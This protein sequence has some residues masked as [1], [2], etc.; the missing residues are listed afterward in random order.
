MLYIKNDSH[1]PRYNIALEEYATKYL[2]LDEEFILLWQNDNSIIIGR[3]QNTVEE[4]NAEYVKENNVTVVRRLSGGGAVY[5]DLGNLNFSFIVKKGEEGIN[6]KDFV[7]PIVNVLQ[8]LGVP[9]EFNSRNDIAIEGKKFSGNAQLLYRDRVLH[10]GTILFNAN[11]DIVQETL[12]VKADKIES[13][14]VKSIRSRVT[15]IVDYLPEPV[16]INEFKQYLLKELFHELGHS[17]VKEYV[18]T[19]E[20]QARIKQLMA[21]RFN[22]WEWNYGTSPA[23]NFKK[24]GRFAGG[25]VE[26]LLDVDGGIIQ[27]CKI[28]GDFFGSKEISDIERRMEGLRYEDQTVRDAFREF[29]ITPY[30]ANITMDELLSCVF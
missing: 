10:H 25:G 28:Y 17:E 4:V 6:F 3:Y 9:A 22:Q 5:H 19:D 7:K 29:N 18:L 16:S 24:S 8:K 21:E 13:K 30:M 26:V 23:F 14:G 20:D 2:N 11:L 15:N 12:K 27:T 1:D